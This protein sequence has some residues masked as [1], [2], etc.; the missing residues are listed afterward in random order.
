M[1]DQAFLWYFARFFGDLG[2]TAVEKR[3]TINL[4]IQRI[5][6][7][8]QPWHEQTQCLTL[9]QERRLSDA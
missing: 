5:E 1:L 7:F 2:L 3:A 9:I 6:S 4:L 8:S